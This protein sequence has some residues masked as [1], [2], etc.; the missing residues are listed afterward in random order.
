VLARGNHRDGHT[1]VTAEAFATR[2]ERL[3][4]PLRMTFHGAD[5]ARQIAQRSLGVNG[6]QCLGIGS[7]R[8]LPAGDLTGFVTGKPAAKANAD[9][10]L[11]G[12]I[13]RR[14]PHRAARIGE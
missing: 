9:E 13:Q 10:V 3:D 12:A 14:L 8:L 2:R 5:P 1:F 4:A 7:P 6:T 11:R